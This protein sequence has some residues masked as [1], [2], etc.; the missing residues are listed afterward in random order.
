MV[1]YEIKYLAIKNHKINYNS[2]AEAFFPTNVEGVGLAG[3]QRSCEFQIG[4]QAS[5]Y[6]HGR[7]ARANHALA[8]A[9]G[10]QRWEPRLGQGAKRLDAAIVKPHEPQSAAVGE[11]VRRKVVEAREGFKML[12]R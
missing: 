8:L 4:L 12:W 7:I 6:E 11:E 5:F 3:A 1:P 9:P 10:G 2:N